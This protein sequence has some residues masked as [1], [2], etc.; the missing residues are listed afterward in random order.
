MMNRH[1]SLLTSLMQLQPHYVSD[2]GEGSVVVKLRSTILE[3]S[4]FR[5]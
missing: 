4:V 1:M 3:M 5:L 2:T